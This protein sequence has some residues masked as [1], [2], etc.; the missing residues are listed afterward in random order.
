MTENSLKLINCQQTL[1]KKAECLVTVLSS[2]SN[3]GRDV[4]TAF[5]KALQNTNQEY[6]LSQESKSELYN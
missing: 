3:K 6:L 1:D 4:R 5:V 2:A